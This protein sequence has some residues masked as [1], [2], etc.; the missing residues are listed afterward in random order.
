MN[1]TKKDNVWVAE[2]EATGDFNIHI[3]GVVEGNI[4]VYQR[5]TSTGAYAYVKGGTP[6]PSLN[7]VYDYDFAAA[8]YP[9]YIKVVCETEPTVAVITEA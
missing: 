2:F 8:V 5:T 6:Y 4:S 9:K 7:N 1:F 3:E